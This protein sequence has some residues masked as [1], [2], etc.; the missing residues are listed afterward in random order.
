VNCENVFFCFALYPITCILEARIN[1]LKL[2]GALDSCP[3]FVF[4]FS[5]FGALLREIGETIPKGPDCG[6]L[7]RTAGD[8]ATVGAVL[9]REEPYLITPAS[10]PSSVCSWKIAPR[11][12]FCNCRG[13]FGVSGLACWFA[14]INPPLRNSSGANTNPQRR[15]S[16]LNV[17]SKIFSSRVRTFVVC[18][19]IAPLGMHVAGASAPRAERPPGPSGGGRPG[20]WPAT[21]AFGKAVLVD[22]A[23][24]L[25]GGLRLTRLLAVPPNPFEQS[26]RH[27]PAP[28]SPN[29]GEFAN[30]KRR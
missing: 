5:S 8:G 22:R 26:F 14:V 24:K 7:R 30:G 9:P 18:C 6:F 27:S 3:S 23:P 20:Q 21:N 15:F 17:L 25:D 19:L 28:K 2:R 4:F 16:R 13:S 29:E 11:D 12:P 1:D 10:A